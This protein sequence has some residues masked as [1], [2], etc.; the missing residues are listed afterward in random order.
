MKFVAK[1]SEVSSCVREAASILVAGD[2]EISPLLGIL[3]NVEGAVL[4]ITSINHTSFFR[5]KIDLEESLEDGEF[6]VWGKKLA[7]VLGKLKDPN[8]VLKV[9]SKGE[10]INWKASKSIC[11]VGYIKEYDDFK[12]VV[13]TIDNLQHVTSFKVDANKLSGELLKTL[14]FALDKRI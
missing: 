13:K 2:S 10:T 1:L 5:K 9:E 12:E 4:T 14:N 6:L 7:E 11:K 8:D 3:V